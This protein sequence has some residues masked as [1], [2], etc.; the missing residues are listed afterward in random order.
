MQKLENYRKVCIILTL[1]VLV[2]D[3]KGVV[4]AEFYG[5]INKPVVYEERLYTVL[6]QMYGAF[7]K[8]DFYWVYEN[9]HNNITN[10]DT[11]YYYMSWNL[12]TLKV[13]KFI[14][15]N[16]TVAVQNYARMENP[17]LE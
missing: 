2:E 11:L 15:R 10:N 8:R 4:G 14:D 16:Y 17:G 9:W 12:S 6:K 13:P 7:H 5:S 3:A 1:D